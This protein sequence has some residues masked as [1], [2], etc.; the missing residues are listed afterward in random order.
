[1]G[2][3]QNMAKGRSAED[4]R[5]PRATLW[6]WCR[7]PDCHFQEEKGHAFISQHIDFESQGKIN[8]TYQHRIVETVMEI[9]CLKQRGMGRN[10]NFG[11][12]Y[13]GTWIC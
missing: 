13:S 4:L 3:V 12:R 10:Q 11:C 9:K 5:I 6:S 7:F 8:H 1:M 2:F